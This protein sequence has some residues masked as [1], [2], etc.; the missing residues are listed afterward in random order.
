MLPRGLETPRLVARLPVAADA[1]SL[2]EAYT[3][4]P[5]VSRY[6][7]WLP[8]ETVS[9]TEA[10][11]EAG[12]GRTRRSPIR[13]TKASGRFHAVRSPRRILE[14]F[15]TRCRSTCGRGRVKHV[16]FGGANSGADVGV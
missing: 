15:N 6:M 9:T 3:S 1:A 2:F 12:S 4:K 13:P 14:F 16:R 7:L 5:K 8:H 11:V 10:F